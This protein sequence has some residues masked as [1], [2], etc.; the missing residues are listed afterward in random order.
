MRQRITGWPNCPSKFARSSLRKHPENVQRRA[1]RKPRF[2]SSDRQLGSRASLCSTWKKNSTRMCVRKLRSFSSSRATLQR[3]GTYRRT[4]RRLTDVIKRMSSPVDRMTYCYIETCSML[5]QLIFDRVC[6]NIFTVNI[7]GIF[8]LVSCLYV[9]RI[10]VIYSSDYS[11]Y[12]DAIPE[13]YVCCISE[14]FFWNYEVLHF[15]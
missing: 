2:S 1:C 13:M 15:F 6:L 8:T 7:C 5:L 10:A 3:T 4:E 14:I 11:K 9:T 12:W